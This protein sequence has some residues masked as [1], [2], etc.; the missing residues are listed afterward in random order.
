MLA[1]SCC[2]SLQR[3]AVVG[4]TLLNLSFLCN[5]MRQP[6]SA[7]SFSARHFAHF[8]PPNQQF[9]SFPVQPYSRDGKGALVSN[10][11]FILL[12]IEQ[13][14]QS[15]FTV[16]NPSPASPSTVS[17]SLVSTFLLICLVRH[18]FDLE[19]LCRPTQ[20]TSEPRQ[21]T[22]AVCV[23]LLCAGCMHALGGFGGGCSAAM[24]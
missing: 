2:R 9:K 13:C 10:W 5:L 22:C 16:Q 11:A 8:C 3:M 1:N 19:S 23:Y 21:I 18:V 12:T 17:W 15:R 6:V 7:R 14:V 4:T 24:C 20:T